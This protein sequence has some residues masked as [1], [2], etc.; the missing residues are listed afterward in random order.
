MKQQNG[1]LKMSDT[2][3]KFGFFLTISLQNDVQL[4]SFTSILMDLKNIEDLK[5]GYSYSFIVKIGIWLFNRKFSFSVKIRNKDFFY[6]P[7]EQL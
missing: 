3:V 1:D 6:L 7:N 4:F 5:I 2:Q